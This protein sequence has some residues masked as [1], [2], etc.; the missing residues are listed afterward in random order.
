MLEIF[1]REDR[2]GDKQSQL[3]VVKSCLGSLST[4]TPCQKACTLP[5][6]SILPPTLHPS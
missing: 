4:V 5:T 1:G 2:R 6:I 3:R